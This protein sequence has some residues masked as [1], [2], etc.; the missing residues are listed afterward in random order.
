MCHQELELIIILAHGI[1][2]AARECYYLALDRGGSREV[3]VAL[4]SLIEAAREFWGGLPHASDKENRDEL[5]AYFAERARG[6]RA[7][8]EAWDGGGLLKWRGKRWTESTSKPPAQ[9]MSTKRADK[10]PCSTL[11]VLGVAV[12]TPLQCLS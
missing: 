9:T 8:Q 4:D 2:D 6:R 1:F 3:D 7:A 10:Q 11:C 5:G 12:Q